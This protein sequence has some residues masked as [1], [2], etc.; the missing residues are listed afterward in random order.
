MEAM[1][2]QE[3]ET[4]AGHSGGYYRLAWRRANERG[5]LYA[6]F[7]VPAALLNHLWMLYRRMYLECAVTVVV[8][9][10]LPAGWHRLHR[11]LGLHLPGEELFFHLAAVP[12]VGFLGN[13]LYLRRARAAVRESRLHPDSARAT[14]VLAERGGTNT[15][16]LVI[17]VLANVLFVGLLMGL[18]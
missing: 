2:E 11:A 10:G 5:G 15:L 4:F 12:V 14:E 9:V 3:M 8:L 1:T 7:N 16:A 6:G 13:V 17:G 18:R